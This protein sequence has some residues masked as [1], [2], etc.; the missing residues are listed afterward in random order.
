M[1]TSSDRSNIARTRRSSKKGV[2]GGEELEELASDCAA[3]GS[4]KEGN[5]CGEE[6]YTRSE[7]V[8]DRSC[9]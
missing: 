1:N 5:S 4:T 2:V 9:E 7:E 3:G 6:E 8:E